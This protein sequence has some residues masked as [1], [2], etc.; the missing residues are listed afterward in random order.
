V[1]L[2]QRGVQG[3]HCQPPVRLEEPEQRLVHRAGSAIAGMI[4]LP[5]G[6]GMPAAA[7]GNRASHIAEG[8]GTARRRGLR[9]RACS[10]RQQSAFDLAHHLDK[11]GVLLQIL[12]P[13]ARFSTI[14][15]TII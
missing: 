4:A 2:D 3:R 5:G 6:R 9:Q 8:D 12:Q 14:S 11:A 7:S 13:P 10:A 15:A 1:G